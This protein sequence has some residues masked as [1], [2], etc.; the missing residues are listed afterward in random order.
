LGTTRQGYGHLELLLDAT[1]FQENFAPPEP[2]RL[3]I[4]IPVMAVGGDLIFAQARSVFLSCVATHGP[5]YTIKPLIIKYR[6]H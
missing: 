5:D 3:H 2:T 1:F 4:I 6:S